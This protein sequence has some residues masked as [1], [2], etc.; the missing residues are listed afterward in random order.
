[1]IERKMTLRRR[2]LPCA[3]CP[4]PFQKVRIVGGDMTIP[5][6]KKKVMRKLR[7]RQKWVNVATTGV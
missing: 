5:M 6:G 1:M 7:R 4:R 2:Y 3:H